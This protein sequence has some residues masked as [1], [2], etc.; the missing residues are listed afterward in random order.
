MADRVAF[1]LDEHCPPAIAEGLRRRGIGVSTTAEAGLLG[2][3][4]EQQL[5]YV[6]T[7]HRVLVTSDADFLRLHQEGVQHAGIV[8]C[9]Q[10]QRTLGEMIR[11]LIL[12]AEL[13]TVEDMASHVEFV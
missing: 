6:L 9:H 1:H 11:S 10:G 5:A 12:I 8:F 13:L 4:D 7:H 2:A 3:P